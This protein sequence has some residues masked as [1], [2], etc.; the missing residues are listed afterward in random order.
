MKS[1]VRKPP[2]ASSALASR[3]TRRSLLK[4]FVGYAVVFGLFSAVS[5]SISFE[6]TLGRLMSAYA[7]RSG[8][9]LLN[10]VDRSASGSDGRVVVAGTVVRVMS[11]CNGVEV[12]TVV[13]PALLVVPIPLRAKIG[14][15][16][17]SILG[18]SVLNSLR[19]ASLCLI[20]VRFPALFE[21]AHIY[22]WQVA[23]IV[24]GVSFFIY[25]TERF[26]VD[27]P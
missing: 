12:L 27:Q 9:L 25:W 24:A 13:L 4:F 18:L 21:V 3:R 17:L 14:G 7:A 16:A 15:I 20:K 10:A 22:V 2:V 19:V 1:S 26:A 11:G 6:N 23:I 5:A 8:A